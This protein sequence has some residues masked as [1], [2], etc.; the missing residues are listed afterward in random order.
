MVKIKH[1][2]PTCKEHGFPKV[3]IDGRPQCVAEYLDRCIG[4]QAVVDFVVREETTYCVFE[5]GLELPILCYCCG[6]P[7]EF[8]DLEETR[9]SMRGRRLKSMSVNYNELDDGSRRVELNLEFASRGILSLATGFGIAP[10]AAAHMI[11]PPDC[12]YR[13]TPVRR[14]T[15]A[16]KRVKK[17]RR[18]RG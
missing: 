8:T 13:G 18:R 14:A 6:G 11:H 15:P 12:R 10:E 7:V 3:T 2:Y 17:K 16:G 9:Q 1:S 5:S 4:K